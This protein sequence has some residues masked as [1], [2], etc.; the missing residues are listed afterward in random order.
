MKRKAKPGC[1]DETEIDWLTFL[2]TKQ[3]KSAFVSKINHD[4]IQEKREF[5]FSRHDVVP[6]TKP[7]KTYFWTVSKLKLSD[8]ARKLKLNLHTLTCTAIVHFIL[9]YDCNF[10]NVT[11][12][13]QEKL[14]TMWRSAPE[15]KNR[16]CTIA[17]FGFAANYKNMT[18]K[19]DMQISV[20]YVVCF[21]KKFK[22]K[23]PCQKTSEFLNWLN[24]KYY[25]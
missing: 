7:K 15:M 14:F 21:I 1:M 5:R 10:S 22:K 19:L 23:K 3:Q 9:N 4:I 20:N 2:N 6:F 17:I 8:R 12:A 13:D 16:I 25:S 11:I 18:C 24:I